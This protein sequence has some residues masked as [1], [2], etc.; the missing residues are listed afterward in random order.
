MSSQQPAAAGGKVMPVP[1]A[2][3]LAARHQE[4]GR[5]VRAE[6]VCRQILAAKPDNADAL[7]LLGVIA[8]QAGKPARAVEFIG[9]AIARDG[10]KALYH[11]NLGEIYRRLGRVDDSVASARRA[12]ALDPRNPQVLNN[13]AIALYERAEHAEAEGLL[14]KA[15]ALNP[16]Y[17]EA[18]S[19]LGNAIRA[20]HR[21]EEAIPWYRQAIKLKP[22]FADAHANL[23]STLKDVGQF[24]EAVECFDRAIAI[25]PKH[26]NARSGRA[27]VLLTQGDFKGGLPEYEWR[28]L[29]SEMRPR[30][31]FQPAWQGENMAG[32]RLLI[33]AEQ[34]Y[35]DTIHFCRYLPGLQARG[36]SV[37][38]E[39]Q[40][41]LV[42]LMAANFPWARVITKE[43]CPPFD[44]HCPMVS[45][46]LAAGTTLE[47]IPSATPYLAADEAAAARWAARLPGAGLRVGFAWGGNPKHRNDFNRSMAIEHL[48]PLFDIP[49]VAFVSLQTGPRAADLS[50]LRNFAGGIDLSAELVDFAESAAVLANLDLVISVDTAVPHLA[51]AMG[52]PVWVMLP[53]VPDWRW[54]LERADSPWYPTM[55]LYRQPQAG[56]WA[57]VVGRIADDLRAAAAGQKDRLL[58]GRDGRRDGQ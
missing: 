19:N 44:R 24:A 41:P 57:T 35:G 40:P 15:L 54:M 16:K 46:A 34:G 22:D 33:H 21:L 2:I 4:A 14:R 58:P 28:W 23:A 9:Q 20:Q 17:A 45:L 50:R 25:D 36:G 12:F 6:K 53:K 51:G 31:F 1:E 27:L 37:V 11:S 42:G 38:L 55:R 10:R 29:S 30:N 52:R 5:L 13:L 3:K 48:A 39:V 7:H 8:H 43:T 32:R 26:G 18:N 49:G 47:T 56:D